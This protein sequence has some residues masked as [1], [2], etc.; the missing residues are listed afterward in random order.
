MIPPVRMSGIA[1]SWWLSLNFFNRAFMNSN[2]VLSETFLPSSQ[3]VLLIVFWETVLWFFWHRL[4]PL[5]LSPGLH[6]GS[7][8]H[9]ETR[10]RGTCGL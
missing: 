2:P 6:R 4:V 1:S 3:T 9:R 8:T 5:D 10:E 7:V